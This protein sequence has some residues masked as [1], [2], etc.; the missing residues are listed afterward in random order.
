MYEMKCVICGTIPPVL[1]RRPW[2]LVDTQALPPWAWCEKC[3][4]E[5]YRRGEVL[6]E[7]CGGYE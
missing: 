2:G 6:C 7:A 1:V 4:R 3:G 5:V